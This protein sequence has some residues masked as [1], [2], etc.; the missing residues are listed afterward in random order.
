MKEANE[1][2]SLASIFPSE[3]NAALKTGRLPKKLPGE[4]L[5]DQLY[6]S[7]LLRLI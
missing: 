3:L 1:K 4:Y 7:A 5:R 6:A 2:V